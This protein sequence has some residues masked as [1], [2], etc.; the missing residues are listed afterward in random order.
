MLADLNR[1]F[2]GEANARRLAGCRARGNR[3]RLLQMRTISPDLKAQL[4]IATKSIQAL[5][6]RVQSLEAE[7]ARSFSRRARAASEGCRQAGG[8][9][10][11]F[12]PSP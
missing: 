2:R 8:E 7:K 10:T 9:S 6:K 5:Q 12:T 3:F 4:E 1:S 11:T